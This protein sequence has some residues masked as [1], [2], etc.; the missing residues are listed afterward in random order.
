MSWNNCPRARARC[1]CRLSH[2]VGSLREELEW[3][4]K[5]KVIF[6]GQ[7]GLRGSLYEELN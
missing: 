3:E 1:G 2:G 4:R 7:E 5:Q 6:M